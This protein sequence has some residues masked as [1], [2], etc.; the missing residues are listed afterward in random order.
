MHV[1][2][3]MDERNLHILN[4]K[5]DRCYLP[6]SDTHQSF[7]LMAHTITLP[8]RKRTHVARETNIPKNSR[9]Q[10]GWVEKY[11]QY[12]LSSETS[13]CGDIFNSVNSTILTN[14]SHAG[15]G[16]QNAGIDPRRSWWPKETNAMR[17]F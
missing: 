12:Y 16:M 2:S 13:A 1:Y 17:Q 15:G 14:G 5:I 3:P 8:S 7:K 10:V 4:A 6:V 9:Q 11:G